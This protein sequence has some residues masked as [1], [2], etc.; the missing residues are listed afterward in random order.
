MSH[1]TKKAYSARWALIGTDIVENALVALENDIITFIGDSRDADLDISD[2]ETTDLGD[3]TLIPGLIN[4]HTHTNFPNNAKLEFEKGS[5]IDWVRAALETRADRSE[6]DQI[7]DCETALKRMRQTG[8]VAL[9]EIS[10]DLLSLEPIAN[11]AMP[12]RYFC[13]RLGF[14]PELANGTLAEVAQT[15]A[16]ASEALAANTSQ[17]ITLHSAPHAPYSTSAELIRGLTEHQTL[18]T[19]HIAEN[20]E[21]VELL[22]TGA[23]PWR[24]R[25]REIG[26]DNETWRAPGISPVEYLNQLGVLSEKL[27]L[28]HASH[29]SDADIH[30]IKRT[31]ASVVLC[32]GSNRFIETGFAPATALAEAGVNLAL[33]TD[34]LGS[35]TDLNVFAEMRELK[36]QSPQLSYE[37]LW[38]IATIGGARALGFDNSLGDLR[39]G[40][41]PGLYS[42]RLDINSAAGLFE[43]LIESGDQNLTPLQPAKSLQVTSK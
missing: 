16:Q 28:V 6:E 18:T 23:G 7:Q 8:I 24:E 35:N 11:S 33:G 26:R 15:I 31:A 14:P 1:I 13:E 2:Y 30:T 3:A 41:A 9:A 21:E 36:K 17:Q 5:M 12:C 4:A 38:E 20:R 19:I 25:L 29:L 43:A 32:P 40:K 10:N 27:L 39:R 22:R 34:S 42:A 37:T